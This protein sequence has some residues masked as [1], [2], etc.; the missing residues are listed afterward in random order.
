M[1]YRQTILRRQW[2]CRAAASILRQPNIV[3]LIV[4][5]LTHFPGLA[6]PIVRY[7]NHAS[8]G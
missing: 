5:A 6:V 4:A 2:V 3:R 1:H 7:I 8:P